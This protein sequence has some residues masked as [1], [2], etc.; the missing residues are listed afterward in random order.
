MRV[1]DEACHDLCVEGRLK[2]HALLHELGTEGVRI[3]QVAVVRDGARTQGRVME[4]QRMRVLRPAGACGRVSRVAQSDDRALAQLFEPGRGEDV[5]HESHVAM[6][7][8]GFPVGNGDARRL[9]AAVLQRKET[10][11]GEVR[12]VD[13][14]L[15]A[16]SEN[17]THG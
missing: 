2:R 17:S 7:T 5:G 6:H 4:R 1:L 10:E 14:L 8:H 16:D 11:V 13:A 9:L 12:H 3:Q 15:G